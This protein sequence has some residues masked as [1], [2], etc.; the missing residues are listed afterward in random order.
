MTVITT[1]TE[2][3]PSAITQVTGNPYEDRYGKE[4]ASHPWWSPI[5]WYQA[6]L[7]IIMLLRLVASILVISEMLPKSWTAESRRLF[8]AELKLI[9]KEFLHWVL[10]ITLKLIFF[11]IA[12]I[13]A[14]LFYKYF[15]HIIAELIHRHI[16]SSL[17]YREYK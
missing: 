13:A 8:Q 3:A 5:A 11:T 10:I 4:D 12:A 9:I 6:I 1:K 2:S 7:A 14:V 15:D 17:Q 16:Y